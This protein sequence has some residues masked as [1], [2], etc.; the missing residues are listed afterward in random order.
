MIQLGIRISEY[1]LSKISVA[2]RPGNP[3]WPGI[4]LC[5]GQCP[6]IEENALNVLEIRQFIFLCPG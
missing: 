4:F 1:A 3:G 2:T 5:P 6:G